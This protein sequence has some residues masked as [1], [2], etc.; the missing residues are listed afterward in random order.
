MDTVAVYDQKTQEFEI[1]SPSLESQKT[2]ISFS[3]K[4]AKAG[5][6]FARVCVVLCRVQIDMLYQYQYND[7]NMFALL[8]SCVMLQLVL[9]NEDKGVHA[10]YV[11]LR[12]DDGRE[13]KGVKISDQG[14][15]WL[16]ILRKRLLQTDADI[17]TCQGTNPR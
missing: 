1:H 7:S 3:A 12:D 14:M 2:W 10:F 4:F 6:V 15:A 9:E 11:P 5:V 17:C 13:L 8:R 16:E